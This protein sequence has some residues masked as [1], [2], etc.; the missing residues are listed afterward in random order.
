[1]QETSPPVFSMAP[2]SDLAVGGTLPEVYGNICPMPMI[3]RDF[4]TLPAM[5][6]D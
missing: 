1:M 5:P 2:R 6:Y 3:P 4:L